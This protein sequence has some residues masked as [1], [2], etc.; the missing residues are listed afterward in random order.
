MHSKAHACIFYSISTQYVIIE[1]C[2]DNKI[3]IFVKHN[4]IA[5]PTLFL[6]G[7]TAPLLPK[8]NITIQDSDYLVTAA[9]EEYR[10]HFRVSPGPTILSRPTSR[11]FFSRSR[12]RLNAKDAHHSSQN[13]FF[14]TSRCDELSRVEHKLF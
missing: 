4:E 9:K 14:H 13:D 5:P 8:H 2:I 7:L 11:R 12:T 1:T 3:G 10:F 6:F